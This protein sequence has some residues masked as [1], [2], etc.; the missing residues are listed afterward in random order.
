LHFGTKITLAKI[1]D[2]VISA[3]PI[4]IPEDILPQQYY[5]MNYILGAATYAVC[6]NIAHFKV[7]TSTSNLIVMLHYNMPL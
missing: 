6:V 4:F 7:R 1:I 2:N 3:R 5:L